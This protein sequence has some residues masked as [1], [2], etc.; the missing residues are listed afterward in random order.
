VDGVA[1]SGLDG[2]GSLVGD[3]SVSAEGQDEAALLG[4]NGNLEG[5]EA[6]L[7]R[8][9][10]PGQLPS[11]QSGRDLHIGDAGAGLKTG[12]PEG[13]LTVRGRHGNLGG[14][15]VGD[16]SRKGDE[17]RPFRSRDRAVA[18]AAAASKQEDRKNED[19]RQ[20][21]YLTMEGS[22]MTQDSQFVL[23]SSPLVVAADRKKPFRRDSLSTV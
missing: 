15:G 19:Y 16:L 11:V 3:V 4:G 2:E 7:S 8:R 22:Q 1:L 12:R 9:G 13:A 23:L 10:G 6:V 20:Q 14:N 18:A 17:A 21:R 5:V